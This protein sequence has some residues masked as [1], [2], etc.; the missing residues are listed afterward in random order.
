[1][2]DWA[3]AAQ[4]LTQGVAGLGGHLGQSGGS[5]GL[6][7]R[8]AAAA[9][10]AVMGEE[11]RRGVGWVRLPQVAL[12]ALVSVGGV[13]AV[14]VLLSQRGSRSLVLSAIVEVTFAPFI[15]WRLATAR[16]ARWFASPRSRVPAR[17]V[18]GAWVTVLIAW[19]AAWG[20]L[21]AWSQS[22]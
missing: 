22:L 2:F 9:L 1:M 14:A 17:R 16:T 20:V 6:V 12:T 11:L 18:R 13:V 4:L 3:L 10:L 21:V 15:A 8:A 5:G 19:A 7:A